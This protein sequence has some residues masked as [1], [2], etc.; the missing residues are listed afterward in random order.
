MSFPFPAHKK[1]MKI[2][3]TT[4]HRPFPIPQKKQGRTGAREQGGVRNYFKTSGYLTTVP[5]LPCPL[6]PAPVPLLPTPRFPN[7]TTW[8]FNSQTGILVDMYHIFS[9]PV[10]S[11]TIK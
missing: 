2:F 7:Q 6:P 3:L 11:L 4:D 10:L 8:N 5:L 1:N 9:Q